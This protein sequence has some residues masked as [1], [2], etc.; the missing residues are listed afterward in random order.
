MATLGAEGRLE[1]VLAEARRRSLIGGLPMETQI[2]HSEGFLRALLLETLNGPVLELGAGGGLPG[3]VLALEAPD[4]QLVLLDSARRSIEFLSWAVEELQFSP[5]VEVV[6]ARAEQL[7]RDAQYRGSFAAVVAR[8]FGP[9]AVTAECASPLL[10][11]GGRLIV[12]EP[13][14]KGAD[15]SVRTA[16]SPPKLDR[17]AAG[18]LPATDRW[19]VDGCAQLG[20]VPELALRDPFGLA[21]LRQASPCPD[22]YPRRAGIPTKRPLFP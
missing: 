5:R 19:P 1:T 20:L 12:S 13:P 4:I 3:L 21:V 17:P 8:S 6:K 7:G 16:T 2:A 10:R 22:R 9:P 14:A 11:V 18:T 15:A